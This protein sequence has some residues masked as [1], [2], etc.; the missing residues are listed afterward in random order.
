MNQSKAYRKSLEAALRGVAVCEETTR[1][2][3][4]SSGS[5]RHQGGKL[6]NKEH[7]TKAQG[8]REQKSEACLICFLHG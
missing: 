3:S 2:Q 1:A 7:G 4:T 8:M 6:Y 5:A